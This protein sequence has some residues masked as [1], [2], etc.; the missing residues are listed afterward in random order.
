MNS[1]GQGSS[2]ILKSSFPSKLSEIVNYVEEKEKFITDGCKAEKGW[3]LLNILV[4]ILEH[5]LLLVS[6]DR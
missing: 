1:M 2:N 3:N 6:T 5:T 4:S